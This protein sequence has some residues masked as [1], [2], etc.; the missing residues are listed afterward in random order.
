MAYKLELP[1]TS[2]VHPIFHVS[3]LKEHVPDHTPVYTDLPSSVELDLLEVLPEE[4]LDRR[5]VKRGNAA[6][7]QILVKWTTLQ[8]AMA[9]WENESTL[10]ARYSAAPVWGHPG[11]QVGDTS[12]TYP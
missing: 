1:A 12:P 9:T 6:L 3:Q 8:V 7:V 2:Q 10:R 4:I 5:L 11:S